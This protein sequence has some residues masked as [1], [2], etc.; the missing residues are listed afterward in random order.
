MVGQV[1]VVMHLQHS[2]SLLG[3]V[4][5]RPLL[6]EVR[7]GSVGFSSKGVE[8]GSQY[9]SERCCIRTKL[10]V[11]VTPYLSKLLPVF[12]SIVAVAVMVAWIRRT[13]Q[14]CVG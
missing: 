11:M 13:V 5:L 4:E 9:R 8:V 3:V 1:K 12:S 10:G 7:R 2:L 6:F 14:L